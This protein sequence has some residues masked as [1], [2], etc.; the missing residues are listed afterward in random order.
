MAVEFSSVAMQPLQ[1][2]VR[3]DFSGVVVFLLSVDTFL[4]YG[5]VS[6]GWLLT[7]VSRLHSYKAT[8]V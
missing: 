7:T 4:L 2:A 3:L 1:A 5:L 6:L 8:W